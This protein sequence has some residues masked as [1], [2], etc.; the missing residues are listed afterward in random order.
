MKILITTLAILSPGNAFSQSVE[1]PST[2][3]DMVAEVTFATSADSQC[4]GIKTRPRKL[5]NYI[6][7][8]YGELA[9]VGVSAN[10]AAQH[11]ATETAQLQIA[12]RDTALRVKHGVAPTGQDAF[13]DAV[14]AE[15][16]VNDGFG[17][18]MRIR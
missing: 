14:R 7:A 17:K 12:E 4:D 10:D 16:K 5:Q 2:A 3:Y 1:L 9:K 8:M 13:C 15:A 6:L 18:L 11:F